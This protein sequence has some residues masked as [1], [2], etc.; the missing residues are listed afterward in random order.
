[1]FYLRYL[2][3]F[4]LSLPPDACRRDHVL[5]MLFVFACV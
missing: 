5:F 1:M 3:L 4:G 2:R